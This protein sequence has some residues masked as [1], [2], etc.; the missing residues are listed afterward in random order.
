MAGVAEGAREGRAAWGRRKGGASVGAE[1]RGLGLSGA[2]GFLHEGVQGRSMPRPKV[3]AQG[4]DLRKRESLCPL[5]H[6]FGHH[7]GVRKAIWPSSAGLAR[8][9]QNQ[10]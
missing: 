4:S 6:H 1:R 9:S 8:D 2:R 3:G 7:F 10:L 5:S